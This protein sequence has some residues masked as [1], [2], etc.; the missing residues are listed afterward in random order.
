MQY[1]P[2]FEKWVIL[3]FNGPRY[4]ISMRYADKITGPWSEPLTVASGAQYAQLYGSF[5]HPLSKQEGGK[6][7]F[8][9]SMWLPYNT[10][11]MSH[12]VKGYR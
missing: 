11:L 7:Y 1:L 12:D 8:V 4:E 6:L 3:Y 10:Y 2:E 9:M 5:I